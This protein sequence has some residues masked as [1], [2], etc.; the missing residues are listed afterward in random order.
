[1]EIGTQRSLDALIEA[2]G[3]SDPEMQIRATDGL[4]NFYLPG[5]VKTGLG[6]SLQRVGRG[7]KAKFTD[8]ND[9]IID[10]YVSVRP[11]VIAALPHFTYRP[12][13]EELT[14]NRAGITLLGN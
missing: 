1:V 2:T 14:E 4:V 5:Y 8:T 6:A 3:D 13:C 9:K 11:E 10:V 7:I 12:V